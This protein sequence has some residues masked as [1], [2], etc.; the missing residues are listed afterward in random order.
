[1]KSG[2][3]PTTKN[4]KFFESK[5]S[6]RSLSLSEDISFN[7]LLGPGIVAQGAYCGNLDH[8]GAPLI[9]QSFYWRENSIDTYT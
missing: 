1:V 8:G 4:D 3:S 7:I 5:I 2:Q 9:N 6:A